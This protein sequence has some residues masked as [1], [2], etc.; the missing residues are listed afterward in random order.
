VLVGRKPEDVNRSV[1]VRRVLAPILDRLGDDYDVVVV[2][3]LTLAPLL[4]DERRPAWV[5]EIHNLPSTRARH[6]ATAEPGR[7]QRWLL[8]RE[9]A[10]ATKFERDV[11]AAYDAAV[12]VSTPDAEVL[13]LPADRVFPNGVAIEAPPS[14]IPD[15][16]TI[17]LPATLD[18]RPNV[19]GATW[20]CDEVLPRIQEEVP[21]VRFALAGRNPI[22]E[23]VALA[24]RPGVE[25]HRDV[26]RM[27]PW[28]EWAR[29]VVVP[30]FVGSGTRLKAL[31]AM[32][33]GRPVVGT[34]IG[35]E[36]LDLVDGVHARIA[37]DAGEMAQA[38]TEL[39]RTGSTA[40]GLAEA[41]RRHVEENF[42]WEAIAS[43]L[44]VA[45]EEASGDRAPARA[46]R[47]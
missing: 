19:L 31:E 24:D 10:N 23:V 9:A 37:D 11:V 47:P 2:Q 46:A 8:R 44:A 26:P 40:I 16:P 13:G 29:V 30:L 42:R 17:L 5:I 18:Y 45:L 34:A 36:G 32:A 39:L 20:F 33:A 14:Q 1:R 15:T 6:E 27:Q 12:V 3:H 21:A 28:L 7:R 35:L 41:A 4:P 43:R 25:L 38:V 22:P